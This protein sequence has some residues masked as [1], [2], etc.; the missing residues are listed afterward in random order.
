MEPASCLVIYIDDRFTVEKWL[1]RDRLNLS[2][3]LT[4]TK[5]SP[6][7]SNQLDDIPEDLE[8]NVNAILAVFNQGRLSVHHMTGR[9]SLTHSHI[10][11]VCRSG[12]SFS[13]K[14]AET[15]ESVKSTCSP[16]FG[17]F[18][19]NADSK[20]AH[21]RRIESQKT[22]RS[23]SGFSKPRPS[24]PRRMTFSSEVDECDGL[25]LLS[26]ISSD[27]QVSEDIK[28]LIPVALV[29]MVP[30]ETPT[31]GTR[32]SERRSFPG[33][34]WQSSSSSAENVSA[35]DSQVMLQCLDA[36][37]L[38]VIPSPLNHE[39]V[40]GL[41][42][43]AYR[44]YKTAKTEQSAFLATASNNLAAA[45]RRQQSWVGI[46]EEEKPYAYLREAMYDLFNPKI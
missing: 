32:Q 14:L 22:S 34:N 23:A 13:A 27:L 10:V 12:R 5:T 46:E 24:L 44:I 17:I 30:D 3:T 6:E 33:K 20:H 25:Q 8:T 38:D 28:L 7:F 21:Q 11:Y 26:R 9:E 36:G 42:V 15:Y 29:R 16:I 1:S 2:S 40:M 45:R 35:I 41:T 19:V 39:K 4:D 37:A 43:H 18:D 31:I